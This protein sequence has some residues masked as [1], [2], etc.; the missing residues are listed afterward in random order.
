LEVAPLQRPPLIQSFVPAVLWNRAYRALVAADPEARPFA[1]ALVRLDGMVSRHEVRVLS[2]SH[3]DA[4]LNE[5]Y[6]E[7]QLKFLLWQ[8]GGSAV[9][10]AGADELAATLART[11]SHTGA[12]AFDH[13]FMGEKVYGETT[14]PIADFI[15]AHIERLRD[16]VA[17]RVRAFG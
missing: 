13:A 4:Q 6:L 17:R 3:P 5:R 8:K 15:A 16:D 2:A 9:I 7:R 1:I 11:Y 10:V 14:L 12:R